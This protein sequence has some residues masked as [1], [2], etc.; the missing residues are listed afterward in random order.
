MIPYTRTAQQLKKTHS[1]MPLA[2]CSRTRRVE[3]SIANDH[4]PRWHHAANSRFYILPV[5]R[6]RRKMSSGESNS[7]STGNFDNFYD[8]ND[9]SFFTSSESENSVE[10]QNSSPTRANRRR[11]T[12][13]S[14]KRSNMWVMAVQLL[15]SFKKNVSSWSEIII[16]IKYDNLLIFWCFFSVFLREIHSF[17]TLLCVT[18]LCISFF[19]YLSK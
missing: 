8:S 1:S 11:R 2:L 18:N 5:D 10:S 17:M 7:V 4:S 13:G 9:E 12:R 19:V 14:S 16:R 15:D 3:T 6:F